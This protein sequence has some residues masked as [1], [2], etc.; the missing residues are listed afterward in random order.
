MIAGNNLWHWATLGLWILVI[1][2]WAAA[3]RDTKADIRT[4]GDGRRRLGISVTL[5][6]FLLLYLPVLRIGGTRLADLFRK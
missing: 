1:V 5:A 3:S 4:Q 2:Y 6:L